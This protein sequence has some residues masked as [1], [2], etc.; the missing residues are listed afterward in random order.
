[1]LDSGRGTPF[2]DLFKLLS[3]VTTACRSTGRHCRL[4]VHTEK[5]RTDSV[6]EAAE[7]ERQ[8]EVLKKELSADVLRDVPPLTAW[9]EMARSLLPYLLQ[10][11]KSTPLVVR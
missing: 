7:D 2:A 1:M 4:S 9:L 10:F 8:M 11:S 6:E 5:R 3:N